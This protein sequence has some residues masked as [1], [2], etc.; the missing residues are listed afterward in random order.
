MYTWTQK[1]PDKISKI[2]SKVEHIAL[3]DKKEQYLQW[4]YTSTKKN[5]TLNKIKADDRALIYDKNYIDKLINQA[6]ATLYKT[7]HAEAPNLSI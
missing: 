5:K 7:Q 3:N 1:H 4:N 6:Y 2:R